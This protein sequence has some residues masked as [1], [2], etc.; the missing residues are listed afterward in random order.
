MSLLVSHITKTEQR[1]SNGLDR[2]DSRLARFWLLPYFGGA[3]SLSH[4]YR[5]YSIDD[6]RRVYQNCQNPC[7]RGSCFRAGVYRTEELNRVYQNYKK[8]LILFVQYSRVFKWKLLTSRVSDS[9]W[10]M[11]FLIMC[12]FFIYSWFY[13]YVFS[14]VIQLIIHCLYSDF[15]WPNS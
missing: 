10:D 5:I 4:I 2:I 14:I 1:S 9:N 15:N 8:L 3:P 7:G 6:Q 11:I 12:N 13:M